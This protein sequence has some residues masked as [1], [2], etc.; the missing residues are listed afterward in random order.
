MTSVSY[1]GY[2]GSSGSPTEFG[3]MRD[4]EAA[5]RE[6]RERGYP[7]DRIVLMGESLGTAVATAV[8]SVHDAAALVLDS[9]YSSVADVAATHYWMFPAPWL[10]LDR[11]RA[12]LAIRHVHLPLLV[13]HGDDDWIVPRKLSQRLFNLANEPKTFISV[14]G[15]GHVVLGAPGV[16][17]RVRVW[18]DAWTG[19]KRDNS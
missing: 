7:S 9:P 11:Y 8:A 4:D 19:V 14:S 3:L 10:L 16:F 12:D 5:Y 13:I 18:I 2:G 1:R 17:Q 15:A 6:I